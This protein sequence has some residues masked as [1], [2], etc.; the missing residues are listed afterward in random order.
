[1]KDEK[2][3]RSARIGLEGATDLLNE[4]YEIMEGA[5]A[6]LGMLYERLQNA[7]WAESVEAAEVVALVRRSLGEGAGMIDEADEALCGPPCGLSGEADGEW[8]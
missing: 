3:G 8:R 7:D 5:S 6:I 1:M 2:A 4:A